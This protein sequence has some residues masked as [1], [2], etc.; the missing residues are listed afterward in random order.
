[1]SKK[2]FLYTKSQTPAQKK[3]FKKEVNIMGKVKLL[4]LISAVVLLFAVAGPVWADDAAKINI[5]KASA[6]ELIR[7]NGKIG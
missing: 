4:A 2:D 5:N 6:E 7:Y 1:L 3:K